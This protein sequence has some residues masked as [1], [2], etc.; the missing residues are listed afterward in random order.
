MMHVHAGL[1]PLW[2]VLVFLPWVLLGVAYLL[3]GA[4]VARADPAPAVTPACEAVG[5]QQ[6]ASLAE[7][8]YRKGEYQRAGRCYQAAGDMA[9]ANLAFL[10]AAGPQSED[11]ARALRAQ[12]D[13]AKALFVNVGKA[14][15]SSH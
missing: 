15:R 8:L 5:P 14:F 6:A 13:T 10:K 4:R 11:T 12:R 1:R 9:H 3:A 2:P 7:A